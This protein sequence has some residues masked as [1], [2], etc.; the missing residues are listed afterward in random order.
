MPGIG[1][2]N[3]FALLRRESAMFKVP[4]VRRGG[5]LT[6]SPTHSSR[7]RRVRMPLLLTLALTAAIA[8]GPTASTAVMAQGAMA[9]K[10]TMWTADG[11]PQY[12][13]IE[14]TLPEFTQLTGI[15]VDFQKTPEGGIID[16]YQVAMTAHSS[17]FDIF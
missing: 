9:S 2:W 14:Q 6:E 12:V 7:Q 11:S 5:H 8:I 17:D 1:S 15:T 13:W 4:E 3:G 16:K 10:I